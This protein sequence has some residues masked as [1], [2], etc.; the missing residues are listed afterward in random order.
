MEDQDYDYFSVNDRL[1]LTEDEEAVYRQMYPDQGSAFAPEAVTVNPF[2]DFDPDNMQDTM[3]ILSMEGEGLSSFVPDGQL[4]DLKW[5]RLDPPQPIPREDKSSY[6]RIGISGEGSNCFFH[7]FCKLYDV[8]YRNSYWDQNTIPKALADDLLNIWKT[9]LPKI[10]SGSSWSLDQCRKLLKEHTNLADSDH[11]TITDS[12]SFTLYMNHFRNHLVAYVKEDLKEWLLSHPEQIDDVYEGYVDMYCQAMENNDNE[13]TEECCQV[14]NYLPTEHL[15][16]KNTNRQW[17]IACV[18]GQLISEIFQEG[19]VSFELSHLCSHVYNINIWCIRERDINVL[20]SK[21]KIY[22]G[23]A[24]I[25]AIENKVPRDNIIMINIDDLHFEGIVKVFE[26]LQT[27][28]SV[29][30][31]IFCKFDL[32]E[33]ILQHR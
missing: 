8:H 13:L 29:E 31:T 18:Q 28:G 1:A 14:L 26:E 32:N 27:D 30:K 9:I 24:P 15:Q 12:K 7:C 16:N 22:Y 3:T 2:W 5:A 10:D 23:D 4:G 33:P 21:N 6:Q 25:V 11:Y 19:S 17:A 20:H